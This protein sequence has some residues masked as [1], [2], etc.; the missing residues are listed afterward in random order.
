MRARLA[1]LATA[2]F[3]SLQSAIAGDAEPGSFAPAIQH[4]LDLRGR[5]GIPGP[6]GTPL[7]YVDAS[8]A[9]HTSAEYVTIAS[10]DDGGHWTISVVGEEGPALLAIAPHVIPEKTHVL[11]DDE[12]RA[13]DRLLANPDLYQEH[14]PGNEPLGIGVPYFVME[15]IT[16]RGHL[17]IKWFGRL[18]GNA[19]QIA[20]LVIGK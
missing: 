13:L 14:D 16:P 7:I 19:G 20:D 12:G 2:A 9:H 6:S 8:A 10:R 11:S 15:I 18:V 1:F 4:G 17:T 3:L 5:Y